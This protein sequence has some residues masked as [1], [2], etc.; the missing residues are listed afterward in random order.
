MKFREIEM[1]EARN[2]ARGPDAPPS[3]AA[4]SCAYD[5]L[6]E[7]RRNYVRP[8]SALR[9]RAR[10][11]SWNRNGFEIESDVRLGDSRNS[12]ILT[13]FLDEKKVV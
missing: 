5:S 7:C 12:E 3:R 11:V 8:T 13:F 6:D 1:L 9:T 10:G 4:R 2:E